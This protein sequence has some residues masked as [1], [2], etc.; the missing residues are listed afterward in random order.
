MSLPDLDF[1]KNSGS[2]TPPDYKGA[3]GDRQYVTTVQTADLEAYPIESFETEPRVDAVFGVQDAKGP[4]YRNLGW[5]HATVLMIK[6]Q[7]G[8]GVLA[9]PSVMHTLGVVPGVITI[10]LVAAMTTWAAYV[11][12]SFKRRH[13]EVYT[14]ADVGQ[15]MF[16]PVGREVFGALYWI[17]LTAVAGAGML[18][19]ATGLNA[20]ITKEKG[21]CHVV[22]VLVGA[23]LGFSV[24]SIQTLEK[25]GWFGWVG[26]AGILSSDRPAA[27][28]A[29]GPFNIEI[30]IIGH[31]SFVE[32][33]NAVSTIISPNFFN[34]VAEMRDPADFTKAM[35]CCQSVVTSTY[36]ILGGVVYHYVGQYIAS[37]A[38]GSAGATM[39]R[40]CYGLA[41][42]GLLVGI[43]LNTHMPAKYVFVRLFKNSPHLASN[44]AIH[45]MGWLG[46]VFANCAI[47]FIIAEAIPIFGDLISLIGALLATFLALQATGMMW[48]WDHKGA[49]KSRLSVK[50]LFG[51]NVWLI[52]GGTFA[53]VA[54]TYTSI[55]AIRSTIASGSTVQ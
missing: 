36:L 46:C 23:I 54:G 26:L 5:I 39:V 18:G 35:L 22:Y 7:I 25:I 17:F 33:I 29:T 45:W 52:V 40:V 21:I 32:A 51:W 2:H 43:V 38:L 24:S 47:S 37:P 4:N 53:M 9:I 11:V 34:I 8:L 20:I 14:L 30:E 6:T 50:L 49:H 10:L 42:P 41:L 16:G 28:P 3:D 15:L 27:A 55:L 12:G 19:F 1:K 13:P 31:P 48:I 44:T